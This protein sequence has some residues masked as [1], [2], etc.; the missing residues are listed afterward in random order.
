MIII[1]GQE[2]PGYTLFVNHHN[3]Q[4]VNFTYGVNGVL[5]LLL[6]KRSSYLYSFCSRDIF[7]N[8]F[9]N[10]RLWWSHVK[11]YGFKTT[12]DELLKAYVFRGDYQVIDCGE[13]ML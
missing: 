7:D 12:R 2:F 11:V 4:A 13:W 8:I 9:N 1:N 5:D 10:N 3:Y 6:N